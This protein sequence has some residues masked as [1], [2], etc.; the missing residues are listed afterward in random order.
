[1]EYLNESFCQYEILIQILHFLMQ[2][3]VTVDLLIS[4]IYIHIYTYIFLY[5]GQIL[6]CAGLGLIT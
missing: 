3:I 6:T 1:M 4:F 2:P 5:M